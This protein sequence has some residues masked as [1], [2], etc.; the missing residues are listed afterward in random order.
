M[1]LGYELSF[2]SDQIL[3]Y[4]WLVTER[5]LTPGLILKLQMRRCV[6]GKDTLRVFSIGAKQ[7][8]RCGV[9]A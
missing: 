4:V 7:S 3:F 8:T 9:P 6:F 1:V 2:K 5:L